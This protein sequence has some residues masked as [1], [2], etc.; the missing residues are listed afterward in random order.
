MAAEGRAPV[1]YSSVV[2]VLLPGW[3][4]WENHNMVDKQVFKNR[5][6]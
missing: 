4:R 6:K 1:R 2:D 5:H 3:D